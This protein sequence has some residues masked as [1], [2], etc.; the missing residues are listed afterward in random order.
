MGGKQLSDSSLTRW[1]RR[2][3]SGTGV[4]DVLANSASETRLLNAVSS[5]SFQGS[6]WGKQVK[7]IQKNLR[8]K[9]RQPLHKAKSAVSQETIKKCKGQ[10]PFCVAHYCTCLDGEPMCVEE[11]TLPDA[12]FRCAELQQ[13]GCVGFVMIGK[14][15]SWR[16]REV[17]FMSKW[18]PR[19]DA[20]CNAYELPSGK[21][22]R[23][24]IRRELSNRAAIGASERALSSAKDA[25]V[26]R[27][28]HA[29][30][31]SMSS[32]SRLAEANKV[33]EEKRK[34][35]R[36]AERELMKQLRA[37]EADN[38][39]RNAVQDLRNAVEEAELASQKVYHEQVCVPF[40]TRP[41]RGSSP[42][43]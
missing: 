38:N 2:G 21:P 27:P 34:D 10:P 24:A 29:K 33:V 43:D 17:R 41:D 37:K 20:S 39:T 5:N 13:D 14:P 18:E 19:Q 22:A 26:S 36:A 30:G 23:L 8:A 32:M 3:M 9:G 4:S 12:K 6:Q 1:R 40:S 28:L 35:L 11:L 16:R 15:S 42:R 7:D 31:V 25:A